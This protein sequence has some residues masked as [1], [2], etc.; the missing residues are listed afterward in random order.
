MMEVTEAGQHVESLKWDD[1]VAA[2]RTGSIYQTAA[3][4]EAKGRRTDTRVV[5][6]RRASGAGG[7]GRG[8]VA[9]ARL[10][11]RRIGPMV[12]AAYVSY[13]PLF[14]HPPNR[15]AVASI[16]TAVE[17]EARAAGC[18]VL[19][20]QPA[21][22]DHETAGH[23]SALGY[24][25]AP[26]DVAASATLV[27]DLGRADDELFR[28]LTKSRRRNV[29]RAQRFGVSVVLGGRADL[30]VLD[31][32]YSAS[33]RRHGFAAMSRSYLER[34]WDALRPGGNMQL[35]LARLDGRTVAAAAMISFGDTVESKITGWDGTARART[36]YVN[37]AVNWASITW[38]NHH[39]YHRFDLGGMPR[40]LAHRAEEIGVAE[41]VKGT[42]SEFK[43]GWGGRLAISPPTYH[44]VIRPSGHLTYGLGSR[45][46]DDSG[47]G[48]RL[49]NW[50]R[51][52]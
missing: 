10:L 5:I 21:R 51:R 29:R 45:L 42:G 26:I 27:V 23:L 13:G 43:H 9:G 8:E 11:I 39:G 34:Q 17:T 4:A 31:R 50:L 12:R 33:A 1:L 15:S 48:G 49:V 7:P 28:D 14:T 40:D 37:D 24:E 6:D 22:G 44:K 47:P 38:A 35:F 25:P 46:L 18:A 19:L 41:A 20:V 2:L 32:L 30:G 36:C 3:W 52:T 16:M